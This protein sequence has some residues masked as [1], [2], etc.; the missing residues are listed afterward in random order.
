LNL[1]DIPKGNTDL[2]SL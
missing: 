2:R 1:T